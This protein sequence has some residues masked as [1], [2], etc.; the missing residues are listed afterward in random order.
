MQLPFD[1]R[2]HL[3]KFHLARGIY[4]C[5]LETDGKQRTKLPE[6]WRLSKRPSDYLIGS[7]P[8]RYSKRHLF[9]LLSSSPASLSSHFKRDFRLLLDQPSSS[10]KNH[11]LAKTQPLSHYLSY[12]E[13]ST[14]SKQSRSGVKAITDRQ[15]KAYEQQRNNMPPKCVFRGPQDISFI[16]GPPVHQDAEMDGSESES[17]SDGRTESAHISQAGSDTPTGA[18]NTR[19]RR[20]ASAHQRPEGG[21]PT[22]DN[23]EASTTRLDSQQPTDPAGSSA[24][25]D[26]S[27]PEGEAAS[28]N[29]DVSVNVNEA[30]SSSSGFA[31]GGAADDQED[32]ETL[33]R[34]A[35]AA[36]NNT[37]TKSSASNQER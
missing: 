16:F 23:T 35:I 1:T 33:A 37:T 8:A 19:N 15:D 9:R 24:D 26:A 12:S 18:S 17:E 22:R 6:K 25:V 5:R 20:P 30:A 21:Q 14:P 13:H 10:I 32:L 27:Q 2:I 28:G 4:S 29:I 3:V 7:W 36:L 31:A 34:N 11:L